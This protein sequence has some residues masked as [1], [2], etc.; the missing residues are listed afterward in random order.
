MRIQLN[1]IIDQIVPVG[2]KGVA[3]SAQLIITV[4]IPECRNEPNDG[5]H[6]KNAGKF[7]IFSYE[8]NHVIL[9]LPM[10]KYTKIEKPLRFDRGFSIISNS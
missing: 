2:E 6:Q 7:F 3:E 5:C 8:F 9:S 10:G 4:L 1:T